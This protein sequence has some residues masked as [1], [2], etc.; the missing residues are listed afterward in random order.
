MEQMENKT[1]SVSEIITSQIIA[2]LELGSVP[3]TVT[4]SKPYNAFS[5]REYT[6]LNKF[7]LASASKK[8]EDPRFLTFNEIKSLNGAILEGEPGNI[9]FY[10]S[11]GQL[12]SKQESLHQQCLNCEYGS[13]KKCKLSLE[14]ADWQLKQALLKEDAELCDD[15]KSK[16]TYVS[17]YYRIWNIQQ[18]TLKDDERYAQ[19]PE[20]VYDNIAQA[21]EVFEAME[22]TGLGIEVVSAQSGYNEKLDCIRALSKSIFTDDNNFYAHIFKLMA[23]ACG[24]E[25]RLDLPYLREASDIYDYGTIVSEMAAV[26]MCEECGIELNIKRSAAYIAGL[27][28]V[29]K[30]DNRFIIMAGNSAN[31]VAN[32]LKSISASIKQAA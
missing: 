30:K 10:A 27:I 7:L 17:K 20:P 3:W 24:H 22:A 6:G 14:K 12:P 28:E 15:F 1:M 2:Q 4:S 31:R 9:V 11:S 29:L 23:N 25:K 16:P 21:D 18:T 5:L 26:I 32:Y 13:T 19:I 8:F